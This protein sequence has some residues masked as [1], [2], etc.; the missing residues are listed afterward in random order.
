MGWDTLNWACCG[1][2]AGSIFVF[3]FLGEDDNHAAFG[4]ADFSQK[5]FN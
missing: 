5:Q 4:W 2:I 3:Y 1:S